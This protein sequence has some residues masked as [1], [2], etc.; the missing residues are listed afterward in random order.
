[1]IRNALVLVLALG[2]SA[3]ALAQAPVPQAAPAPGSAAIRSRSSA[4]RVIKQLKPVT[5]PSLP[6]KTVTPSGWRS[7]QCAAITA[8][9]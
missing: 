6:R 3:E 7:N 1:M 9:C 5:T 8:D 4:R 2:L